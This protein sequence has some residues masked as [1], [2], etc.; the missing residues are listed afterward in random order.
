MKKI[1]LFSLIVVILILL[2]FVIGR[3]RL[4]AHLIKETQAF[5]THP[6]LTD[7][8]FTYKTVESDPNCSFFSICLKITQL[9][10]HFYKHPF[11][12]GTISG[13]LILTWPPYI[14]IRNT[15]T[16]TIAIKQTPSALFEADLSHVNIA[17][18]KAYVNIGI[19]NAALS[20][21]YTFKTGS[22]NFQA[23]TQNLKSFLEPYISENIRPFIG[24][25]IK[26]TPQNIT[27]DIHDHQLTIF[28]IPLFK[29]N[30][31]H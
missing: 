1:G 14:N 30:Q 13:N 6:P 12:L 16:D 18:K 9:G 20:G 22:G 17:L 19:L 21:T 25:L 15:Q 7:L 28:G 11:Y 31:I 8:T 27:A 26:N 29:F 24:F 10:G 5:L 4:Q 23:V 3:N 2:A